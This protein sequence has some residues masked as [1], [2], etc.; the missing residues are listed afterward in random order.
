MI[1]MGESSFFWISFN[2]ANQDQCCLI[3]SSPLTLQVAAAFRWCLGSEAKKKA[4]ADDF[5]V[6]F[7]WV[8]WMKWWNPEFWLISWMMFYEGW[9]PKPCCIKA[10]LYGYGLSH[11]GTVNSLDADPYPWNQVIWGWFALF[12]FLYCESQ[13]DRCNR[14][15]VNR[16]VVSTNLHIYYIYILLYI[17][18][19]QL[20]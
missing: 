8:Y 11:W 6:F 10:I 13:W 2:K 5:L 17:P 12:T 4:E 15:Y 1:N 14:K 16:I 20:T 18:S 9:N 19:S 7:W 3:L